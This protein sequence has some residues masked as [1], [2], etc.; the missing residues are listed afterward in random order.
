M[1][2]SAYEKVMRYS[3]GLLAQLSAA[4]EHLPVTDPIVFATG[5]LGR[6]EA[7]HHSNIDITIISDAQTRSEEAERCIRKFC[8]ESLIECN[9]TVFPLRHYVSIS[10]KSSSFINMVQFIL[11][12]KPIHA[13]NL[14]HRLLPDILSLNGEPPSSLYLMKILRQYWKFKGDLYELQNDY[15]KKIKYNYSLFISYISMMS[16]LFS[17]DEDRI[18]TYIIDRNHHTN[19]E[20]FICS[21]NLTEEPLN[22][23][24]GMYNEYLEIMFIERN[25][26]S[27]QNILLEKI[28]VFHDAIYSR[29]KVDDGIQEGM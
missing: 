9:I 11:E 6:S 18:E 3:N 2:N 23:L 20:K 7:Y 24:F 4:L 27:G 8:Q 16:F 17:N 21:A 10:P 15:V 29:V 25:N 28:S 26:R 5:S 22:H 12:S 1:L 19:W 14:Y 13:T